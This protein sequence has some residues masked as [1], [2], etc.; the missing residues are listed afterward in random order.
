MFLVHP[1][2]SQ[3]VLRLTQR[4]AEGGYA[5]RFLSLFVALSFFRLDGESML[6]PAPVTQTI[7]ISL[8]QK[9]ISIIIQSS[10]HM[11]YE[12]VNQSTETY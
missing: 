5:P 2:V 7:A 4:A 8:Y 9:E 3:I 10:I 12:L 11:S 1:S 6:A